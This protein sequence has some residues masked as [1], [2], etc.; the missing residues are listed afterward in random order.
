MAKNARETKGKARI[1]KGEAVVDTS[2][3]DAMVQEGA[4]ADA[5]ARAAT[6]PREEVAEAPLRM[7]RRSS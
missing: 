5:A 2:M 1:L 4:A 6:E 7:R 3:V